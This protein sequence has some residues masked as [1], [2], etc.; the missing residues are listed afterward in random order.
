MASYRPI[1]IA[2]P[3]ASG[4]SALAVKLAEAIGGEIVNAD[5]MQIY[6]GLSILTAQPSADDFARVPHH[7]F[8]V[9]DPSQAWSTGRWLREVVAVLSDLKRRDK[10]AL[11]VGGTGLY[12]T[13]LTEGLAPMP[14]VP[15]SIRDALRRRMETEGPIA[16]HRVLAQVDPASAARIDPAD[17]QRI[18]RALEVTEATGKPFSAW[19]DEARSEAP[20]P[21]SAD[22]D[23]AI[24]AI[25]VVLAPDR[26]TRRRRIADRFETMQALG[27]EHEAR[28]FLD[29]NLAPGLPAMKAIGISEHEALFRGEFDAAELKNRMVTRTQRYS[30]RQMTWFR[31]QFVSD[32][33]HFATADEACAHVLAQF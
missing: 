32:W 33:V 12:F 26:E 15:P 31:N 18:V 27:M 28:E 19:V 29:R 1:L 7:L 20:C 3:T 11:I 4:K 10:P 9:A 16:L 14:S 2:G 5:S 25:A 21:L 23:D 17:R 22:P 30:K 24:A 8:G 6:S 13:A